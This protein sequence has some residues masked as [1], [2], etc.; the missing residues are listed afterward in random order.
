MVDFRRTRIP[1]KSVHLNN[2]DWINTEAEYK[3]RMSRL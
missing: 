3:K 1:T 2:L